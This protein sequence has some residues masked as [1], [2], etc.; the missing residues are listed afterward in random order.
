MR[1]KGVGGSGRKEVGRGEREE[2]KNEKLMWGRKEIE[3]RGRERKRERG[4]ERRVKRERN[5]ER[6]WGTLDCFFSTLVM[7]LVTESLLS[8]SSSSNPAQGLPFDSAPMC[9]RV[10]H[11][12]FSLYFCCQCGCQCPLQVEDCA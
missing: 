9:A 3:D 1:G 5:E 2:R 10:P 4:E 12:P 11:L 7:W 8:L 6:M